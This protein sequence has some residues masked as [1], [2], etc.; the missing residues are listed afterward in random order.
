MPRT[1]IRMP[2]TVRFTPRQ[3][4]E[5]KRQAYTM[6]NFKEIARINKIVAFQ[7]GKKPAEPKR[8]YFY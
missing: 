1:R 2:R 8:S 7:T 6:G 3:L 5:M 4:R